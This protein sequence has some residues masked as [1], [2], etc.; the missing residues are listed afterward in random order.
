MVDIITIDGPAS[1]GKGTVAKIIAQQ[2]KFN[3][4]DSGS[5]YRVVAL[6]AQ[7]HNLC[8]LNEISDQDIVTLISRIRACRLKFTAT[9]IMLNGEDV[10][11]LIRQETIGNI[12]SIISGNQ[13]IRTELLELQRQ[14]AREP[15]L[16]TDG[17]DMGTIVFP[18]AKLKIFLQASATIRAQR[19]FEQLQILGQSGTIGAI[20]S[21][22]QQRDKRDSQRSIAPMTFD[23]TFKV[24]DNSNMTINETVT[25]IIDWYKELLAQ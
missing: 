18:Q 2:L 14:F 10:S 9:A 25:K 20:L 23:A 16:V 12:A 3:F 8:G 11:N 5:I 17:R 24:L 6:I 4:L 22:I 13:L 19:R 15:G 21:D 1:S 7:R